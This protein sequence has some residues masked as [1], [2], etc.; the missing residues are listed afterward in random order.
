MGQGVFSLRC[1]AHHALTYILA[2]ESRTDYIM[3]RPMSSYSLGTPGLLQNRLSCRLQ[4][5]VLLLSSEDS[6]FRSVTSC[7]IQPGVGCFVVS[8]RRESNTK[9]GDCTTN[10]LL[11]IVFSR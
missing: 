9:S 11:Y 3:C 2:S 4:A 10:Q 5:S 1:Q 6:V 7:R 8:K